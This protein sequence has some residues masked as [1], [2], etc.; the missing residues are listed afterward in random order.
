[1][2][3]YLDAGTPSVTCATILCPDLESVMLTK[4]RRFRILAPKR[5]PFTPIRRALSLNQYYYTE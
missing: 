5:P 4:K 2:G 1:M 3:R